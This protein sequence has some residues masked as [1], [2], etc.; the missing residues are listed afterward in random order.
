MRDGKYHIDL[1]LRWI[2]GKIVM[3]DLK[4]EVLKDEIEKLLPED[5]TFKEGLFSSHKPSHGVWVQKK[6]FGQNSICCEIVRGHKDYR[7][8]D[9]M[10]TWYW[11]YHISIWYTVQKFLGIPVGGKYKL[12]SICRSIAQMIEEKYEVK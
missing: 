11:T 5:F 4:E 9:G 12:D 8:P 7:M 10:A 2:D 6:R 1:D 3:P